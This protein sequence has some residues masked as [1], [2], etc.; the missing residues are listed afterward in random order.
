MYFCNKEKHILAKHCCKRGKCEF[1]TQTRG[2]VITW[3]NIWTKGMK[4]A[5]VK[6]RVFLKKIL[7]I[8][9][10]RYS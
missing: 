8:Y 9:V 6:K 4:G 5:Q 10:V 1:R 3:K 2:N 7:L